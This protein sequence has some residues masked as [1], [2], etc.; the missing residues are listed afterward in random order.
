MR[1]VGPIPRLVWDTPTSQIGLGN[2][3]TE[4]ANPREAGCHLG[5]Q[6]QDDARKMTLA[7]V[8]S[9]S[10][11]ITQSYRFRIDSQLNVGVESPVE[12]RLAA[13]VVKEG[14]AVKRG[15]GLVF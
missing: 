6:P 4:S 12:G 1:G 3:V 13:I 10:A 8:R 14:Q 9:K 15:D 5:R 2:L 11:T 7:V